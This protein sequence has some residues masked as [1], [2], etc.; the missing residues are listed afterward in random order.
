MEKK[1]AAWLMAICLRNSVIHSETSQDLN[2]IYNKINSL[3][4]LNCTKIYIIDQIH[5]IYVSSND[6]ECSMFI[7]AWLTKSN[8]NY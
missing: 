3:V 8:E 4:Q 2:N 1:L 6:I 5:K 7:L